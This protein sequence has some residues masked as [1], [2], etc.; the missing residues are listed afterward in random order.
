MK[1][2]RAR[3]RSLVT[4]ERT[5]DGTKSKVLESEGWMFGN[6]K[7][8]RIEKASSRV[9]SSENFKIIIEMTILK[10]KE[11]VVPLMLGEDQLMRPIDII[12][13]PRRISNDA[14]ILRSRWKL[15]VLKKMSLR[16]AM[17]V[18]EIVIL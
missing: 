17:F 6:L 1:S 10:R 12:D 4:Y 11:S 3:S 8:L 14:L 16:N 9:Y 7:Q 5:Q 18:T 15:F 2:I 13:R